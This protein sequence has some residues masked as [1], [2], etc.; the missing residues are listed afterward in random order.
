MEKKQRAFDK[1]ISEWQQKVK[2]LENDIENAN[3][4]NRNLSTEVFRAKTQYEETQDTIEGLRRENKN[5][6]GL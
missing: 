3:R 2:D 1:T 6:S 5:L 4:E